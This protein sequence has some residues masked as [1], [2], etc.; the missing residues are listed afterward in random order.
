MSQETESL[1][2]LRSITE[3]IIRLE[4][5]KR[6]IAAAIKEV[7]DECKEEGLSPGSIRKLV[8]EHFETPEA[9]VKREE[10]EAITEV[11]KASLGMLGG[12]P[13]G[14]A[15]RYRLNRHDPSEDKITQPEAPEQETDPEP[16]PEQTI[17]TA[18]IA[19]ARQ[20]G[21]DDAL[22]GKKILENPFI[23]G[24]PRRAAWDEGWCETSGSDGMDIP[25]AWKPK[26]NPKKGDES[27]D[28]KGGEG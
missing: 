6:E 14:E 11:Y 2:L 23:S 9:K 13:L 26:K 21:C 3:R 10:I 12:T 25:D 7:Y 16:D 4:T 18:D 28:G 5:E 20:R 17:S 27:N 1:K 24:D 19:V 15:A 8:R 22:A